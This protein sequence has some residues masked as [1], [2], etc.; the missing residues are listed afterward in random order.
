MGFSLTFG[1]ESAASDSLNRFLLA[2]LNFSWFEKT[3][4]GY[5]ALKQRGG[6]GLISNENELDRI[7]A[8]FPGLYE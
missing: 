5:Q 4:I 7:D 8:G 6:S 1:A 3:D 2:Q